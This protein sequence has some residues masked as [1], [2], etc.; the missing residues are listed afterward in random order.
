MIR[1][2]GGFLQKGL[3]IFSPVITTDLEFISCEISN[4][5]PALPTQRVMETYMAGVWP[6]RPGR[7]S[8]A[9]RYRSLTENG[10]WNDGQ[11]RY[12][13]ITVGCLE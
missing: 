7:L 4:Y 2:S 5:D 6:G 1:S 12:F 9:S 8:T 3:F 10:F 11:K 13:F